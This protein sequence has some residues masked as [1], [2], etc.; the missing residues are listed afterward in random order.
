MV[1]VETLELDLPDA[2]A[3]SSLGAAMAAVLAPGDTVLLTGDVGAGKTHLARSIIQARLRAAG[4][5]IEDVPSPTFTL[6]QVY[7]DGTGEIWHTDLYRVSNPDELIELGLDEA[8]ETA[9]VLVEWPDRLQGYPVDNS[10]DVFLEA[11]GDGRRASI[12]AD[13][14]FLSRLRAII[15]THD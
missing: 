14:S 13:S 2:D 8:F 1:A 12:K 3:T 4:L 15:E 6:V 11:S 5:Q 9:I 10:V 7:E